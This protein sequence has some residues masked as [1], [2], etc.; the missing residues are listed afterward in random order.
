MWPPKVRAQPGREVGGQVRI[1][2]KL[3]VNNPYDLGAVDRSSFMEAGLFVTLHS[4]SKALNARVW[5]TCL[6]RIFRG[7]LFGH[8]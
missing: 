3:Q 7:R 8:E 4:L 6:P 1:W 5:I 2:V